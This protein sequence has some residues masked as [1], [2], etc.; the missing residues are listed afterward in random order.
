MKLEFIYNQSLETCKERCQEVN[1]G[2]GCNIIKYNSFNESCALLAIPK[3][4]PNPDKALN[5]PYMEFEIHDGWVGNYL[6]TDD[7]TPLR[8]KFIKKYGSVAE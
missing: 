3:A 5:G 8:G 1:S 2:S 7:S 4:I 6:S